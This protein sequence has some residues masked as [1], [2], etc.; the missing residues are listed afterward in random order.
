MRTKTHPSTRL[1]VEWLEERAVPAAFFVAINGSDSAAGTAASPWKTLQHAADVV[2]AGDTVTVKAGSY[3]GFNLNTDGTAAS[4]ITFTGEAGAKITS[5]NPTTADGINLEGA[6]YITIQG[7]SI[8][9]AGR[10]GIRSVTNHD[11]VI[12]NNNC[13][14]NAR[15]GIFTGFSDNLTIENNVTSRSAQEHGIYVSNSGDNPVIRGNVAWGNKGA[16]IHMNGDVSQGGDGIISNALVE[17][18]VLYSNGTGGGSAINADGVQNSVFR[19]NLIYNAL[20]AGITL[21]RQDGGGASSGNLVENNTVLVASTGRWALNIANGS[22]NNTVRNN[23]LYS[24]QSF[25]GAISISADSL[26]GFV[27]DYNLTENVFSVDGGN[28]ALSLTQWRAATGRD[29]HSFTTA[30]PNSLFVNPSAGDYHLN[31]TSAAVDKGTTTGAP[32]TDA[33]GTPR[34]SGGGVDIGYDELATSPPPPPPPPASP[35]PPPPVTGQ[36][37]AVGTNGGTVAE[38]TM[39]NA[40]RTVRFTATPF[41][42]TYTGEARVAVGDVTGDGIADIV[43]GSNGLMNAQMVIVDGATG[44]VR[45]EQFLATNHYYGALSVA[46]GDVTGDGI[47]DIAVGTTGDRAVR[48]YRG[49]DYAKLT[50][51]SAGPSTGYWGQTQVALGDLNGDGKADLV[52]SSLYSTGITVSGFTGT[53]LRAGST[54]AALFSTFSP[55]AEVSGKGVSLTIGDVNADGY[56]D[57]ILGAGAWGNGRVAVYSGKSLVQANSKVVLANFSPS[58]AVGSAG[59]RVAVR[60]INGDGKL[61]IVTSS[62]EQVTAYNGSSLPVTG[63]PP[64]LFAFDPDTTVAGGVWIG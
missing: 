42:S 45:P 13:D 32:P 4:R 39:Y 11:V 41:G 26:S 21:F 46:V 6:D 2:R 12:R 23:I 49:G 7:F 15:W 16:G 48:V 22:T 31:A 54:P 63:L 35:P 60:D 5:R 9:G 8:S 59:I 53:S 29:A 64:G 51:F 40:D 56:G 55:G 28:T 20:A 34:P 37:F 3:A 17:N 10:A 24:A 38:V 58:G 25:R 52:V 50:E 47:A 19:N 57:L 43:V 18:N 33:E 14:S 1:G 27:S 61:D 30:D 36:P 44:K 62:G